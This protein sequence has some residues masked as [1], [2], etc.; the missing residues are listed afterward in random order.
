ME[1]PFQAA[2]QARKPAPYVTS[3]VVRKH[4]N[5][6]KGGKATWVEDKEVAVGVAV[7]VAVDA[8]V[9][10]AVAPAAGQAAWEVPK[11]QGRAATA[12][13]RTA[14]TGRFTR[15]VSRAIRWPV[16]SAAARWPVSSGRGA[17]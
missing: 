8:A 2:R 14:A 1:Q 11:L 6:T 16:P 15:L 12:S 13:A 5:E 9:V 4:V 7:G 3:A 10:R 17:A